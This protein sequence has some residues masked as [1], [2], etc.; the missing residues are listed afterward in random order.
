M[1]TIVQID[2]GDPGVTNRVVI[3]HGDPTTFT[4]TA[5]TVGDSSAQALAANTSRAYLQIKNESATATVAFRLGATAAINTAGSIT[6]GPGGS[7]TYD[8]K[9][10]TAAIN[11][12]ASVAST[13]ATILSA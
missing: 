12:I 9:C 5:V 11:M 1:P 6:L 3:D 10:P 13:P 7:A 2:Q 4:E 8:T